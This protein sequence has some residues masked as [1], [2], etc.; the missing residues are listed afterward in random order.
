MKTIRMGLMLA[1]GGIF[2]FGANSASAQ[3]CKINQSFTTPDQRFVDHGDGTVTDTQTGLMWK[4]CLEGQQSYLCY[5]SPSQMNWTSAEL[6]AHDSK[7]AGRNGWRL[8]TVN[9]LSG[10]VERACQ[11]PA[12][13]LKVFPRSPTHSLWS[14]S[15]DGPN[16]WSVD[17]SQG[18]PF[19][20]LQMGGKYVRLVRDLR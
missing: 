15:Q 18:Q 12:I 8:P 1:M 2:F 4:R 6:I 3:D 7:F 19:Q 16:A 17:F 9:E 14:S 10:I 5:G 13:N 20:S 11:N